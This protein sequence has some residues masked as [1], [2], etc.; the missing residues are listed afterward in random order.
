MT[1]HARLDAA[2][3]GR[4]QVSVAIESVARRWAW[5]RSVGCLRL[6]GPGARS[7]VLRVSPTPAA[8]PFL[9]VVGAGFLLQPRD[10]SPSPSP[11]G[12]A[13]WSTL[14]LA[15]V[16]LQPV[17]ASGSAWRNSCFLLLQLVMHMNAIYYSVY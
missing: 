15:P 9:F 13:D 1:Q 12:A 10:R 3:R 6:A 8:R 16:P 4:C 11:G 5:P 17:C 14:L 7:G 2:G